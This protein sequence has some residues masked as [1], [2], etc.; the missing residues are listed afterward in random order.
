MKYHYPDNTKE[1]V[2]IISLVIP[3]FLVFTSYLYLTTYYYFFDINIFSYVSINT[4]VLHSVDNIGL[5][6]AVTVLSIF[7]FGLINRIY[8]IILSKKL[9]HYLDEKIFKSFSD[10][11]TFYLLLLVGSLLCL[12]VGLSLFYGISSIQNE[13]LRALLYYGIG[14]IFM[15]AIWNMQRKE[16]G[17][18]GL[19]FRV[20][21]ISIVLITVSLIVLKGILDAKY[22]KDNLSYEYVIGSDLKGDYPDKK[23]KL[24]GKA[25]DHY[26]LKHPDKEPVIVKKYEDFKRLHIHTFRD[27]TGTN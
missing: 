15:L 19:N 11:I 1:I 4:I 2:K 12:P 10:N 13:V 23:L 17:N 26:F 5:V 27:T 6:V 16:K 25:D 3:F 9:F 18:H 20:L 7:I 22:F 8:D 24:I 21:L 14:G